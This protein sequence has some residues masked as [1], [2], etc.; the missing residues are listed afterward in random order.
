MGLRRGG[1]ACR[2]NEYALKAQMFV[3]ETLY[4]CDV[5]TDRF[6]V[7]GEYTLVVYVEGASGLEG[8]VRMTN[9]TVPAMTSNYLDGAPLIVNTYLDRPTPN[10][11]AVAFNP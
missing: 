11:F 7:G 5:S 8:T 6:Q 2:L 3:R 9:F 10:G 4:D 1:T